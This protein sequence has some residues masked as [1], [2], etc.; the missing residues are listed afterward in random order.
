MIS[1]SRVLKCRRAELLANKDGTDF[2]GSAVRSQKQ[3]EPSTRVPSKVQTS[4]CIQIW[5][6][7][8]VSFRISLFTGSG[9]GQMLI[10][11]LNNLR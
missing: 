1:W 3:K 5:N 2:K 6:C 8:R 9:E 4:A 10:A 11:G 7:Y